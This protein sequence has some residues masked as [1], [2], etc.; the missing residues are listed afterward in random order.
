M[1][2]QLSLCESARAVSQADID[3]AQ[4]TQQEAELDSRTSSRQPPQPWD[5]QLP[6]A[7]SL[8]PIVLESE[9]QRWVTTLVA[10]VSHHATTREQL[11]R[12]SLWH[13]HQYQHK[14]VKCGCAHKAD[15]RLTMAG[16]LWIGC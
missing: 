1:E 5:P 16:V 9:I 12:A 15:R 4:R 2:L 6:P 14:G 7:T 11:F 10:E 8:Q 13:R 3:E